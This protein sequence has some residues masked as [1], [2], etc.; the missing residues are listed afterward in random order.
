MPKQYQSEPELVVIVSGFENCTTEKEGFTHLS[1]LVVGT[2]YL[3][4]STP[5][6][7]FEKMRSGLLRFLDHHG[8]DRSKYKDD[9][10]HA[11]IEAIQTVIEQT[12]PAASLVDV[13]NTVVERLSGSRLTVET[14]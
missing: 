3:V 14:E 2:Y 9:V 11:W 7:A 1:H 10:T 4:H 8:I 13:T 6:D 5:E 12:G